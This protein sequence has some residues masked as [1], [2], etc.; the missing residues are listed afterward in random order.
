MQKNRNQVFIF[1]IVLKTKAEMV[2]L[3]LPFQEGNPIINTLT[4]VLAEFYQDGLRGI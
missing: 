3:F 4:R 2:C 1:T